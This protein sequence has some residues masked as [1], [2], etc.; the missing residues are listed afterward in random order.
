M[1]VA[2]NE[3]LVIC[4]YI[5]DIVDNK[6]QWHEQATFLAVAYYQSCSK[7]V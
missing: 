1:V 3:E 6:R 5:F 4:N 7:F 2:S